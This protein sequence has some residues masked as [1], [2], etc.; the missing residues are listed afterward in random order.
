MMRFPF[1]LTA[2]GCLAMIGTVLPAQSVKMRVAEML[3][4]KDVQK[5]LQLSGSQIEKIQQL[6]GLLKAELRKVENEIKRIPP[7]PARDS[8]FRQRFAKIN[9]DVKE[10]LQKTLKPAQRDRLKQIGFQQIGH[11]AFLDRAIQRKLK[12]I[13]AQILLL[14]ALQERYLKLANDLKIQAGN[15]PAKLQQRAIRLAELRDENVRTI[16]KSFTPEQERIWKELIG[17]PFP[18]KGQPVTPRGDR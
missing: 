12:L 18:R 11:L 14:R 10:A 9:A 1:S 15:D 7:G 13:E 16:Q 17:P 4:R 5:E 3:L 2:L 8:F 6:D